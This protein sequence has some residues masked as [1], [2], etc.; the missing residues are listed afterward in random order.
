MKKLF[1]IFLCLAISI[2]LV[3]CGGTEEGGPSNEGEHTVTLIAT[4]GITVTSDN[5]VKVSD[6]GTA[7]FKVSCANNIAVQSAS[8]GI[9]DYATGTLRITGVTDDLRV[10]LIGEK[11]SFDTSKVYEYSFFGTGQD[12]SDRISGG[13]TLGVRISVKA[14]LANRSFVGWSIGG[15]VEYGGSIVSTEREYTFVASPDH[16]VNGKITLYANYSDANVYYIHPNGGTV[17]GGTPNMT[18]SY[19]T[20]EPTTDNSLKVSLNKEY[21][22]FTECASTFYDDGTFTRTGYVLVE[23]NTKPDGTGEGYS[24]GSKFPLPLD[25]ST[26]YCIWSPDT[27]HADFEY[28]DI[29][30]PLPTGTN[31]A[32]APHWVEDGVIITA[33]KGDEST[34]TIPETLGGKTVIAIAS[35]AFENKKMSTLV[36]N[37]RIISIDD[38]AFVSCKSLDKIYYPDGIYYIEN[39]A[40]DE[41]SWSG[42]KSLYVNATIA[43]RYAWSLE[44]A[45]AVKFTRLLTNSDK[46]RIVIISG[47]SSFQGLSAAYLEALLDG[48]YCVVNFGTTRTTQGYMFLEAMGALTDEDD[49]LLFAPENS[50]YMMGEPRLYWKTLRD[51]E[52]MYNIFR[53]ID[54]SGYTNVLGAF[55]EFNK[56]SE[57]DAYETNRGPRYTLDPGKYEDIV[58]VSNINEYGEYLV[59]DRAGYVLPDNKYQDVYKITLNN[60]FKSIK[61]GSY[62]K[63]DPNEDYYTSEKW[64]DITDP[65]YKDNMNRAIV[66]AKAGGAKVYFTFCPVD[67]AK[68][69]DEVTS[70]GEEWL[71]AYEKMIE[72]N[73]QFDGILGSVGTYIY[74]HKYFYNNAFHLNDYG[75][76]YRTY[77]M[78]RDLATLL[79]KSYVKGILAVGTD[80]E[81]CLFESTTNG[82]PLYGTGEYFEK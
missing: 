80:F 54:I 72:D 10:E 30:I 59:A 61:E 9:Y 41:D 45:Y 25:T 21:Y 58:K 44:G 53:H 13:I 33:Y 65:Y 60:R 26:L 62:L 12:S 1:G 11:V 52:G 14:G 49:I 15:S 7:T 35:G 77:D 68:L 39:D 56:G 17:N 29:N 32:K 36:L 64:C 76:T 6:G 47:S 20:I 2:M 40:F 75:R 81:G 73:Y 24:L 38:G 34:V 69:S 50:A 16:L 78:Y 74:N 66:A 67:G 55:S 37:R 27:S 8:H 4:E 51:L 23:Y 19:Y 70:G 22:E 5:P 42:V 82:K 57:P 46:E 79:G 3:A 43:P 18:N 28:E 71:A 48:R 31:A 63:S